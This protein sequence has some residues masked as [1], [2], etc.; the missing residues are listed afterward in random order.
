MTVRTVTEYF[1]RELDAAGYD[2]DDI[3][4]SLGYCQGDGMDFAGRVGR[5]EV[6]RLYTRLMG[7]V[8]EVWD[9]LSSGEVSVEVT[10]TSHHYHHYNTMAVTVEWDEDRLR[11]AYDFTE[12]QLSRLEDFRSRVEE[13]VRDVSRRLE[14]EGYAILEACNPL[15]F[16]MSRHWKSG[17]LGDRAYQM[18]SFARG[19]FTVDVTMVENDY[20]DGYES[21]DDEADHADVK[22]MVRGEIVSYDLRVRILEDGDKVYEKWAHGVTDKRSE[23]RPMVIAREL[24]AAARSAIADKAARL[25]RFA[26][27]R[28]CGKGDGAHQP[29]G[30]LAR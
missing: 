21:G 16:S 13:D 29:S 26:G 7:G 22:R 8:S 17:T 25:A 12:Q 5:D 2:L 23:I 14:K 18:R 4:W 28:R 10:R 24:L 3:G 20:L 30:S 9:A 19:S 6:I 27:D 15:W 11:E 1:R